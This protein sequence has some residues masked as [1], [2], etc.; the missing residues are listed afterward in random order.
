VY[1]LPLF[2]IDALVVPDLH[3]VDASDCEKEDE[4][5]G[6]GYCVVAE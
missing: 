3:L 6:L 2:L 5:A 1:L 4:E